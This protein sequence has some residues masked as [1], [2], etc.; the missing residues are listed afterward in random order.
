MIRQGEQGHHKKLSKCDQETCIPSLENQRSGTWGRL[1]TA[2]W[3]LPNGLKLARR[4][5]NELFHSLDNGFQGKDLPGHVSRFNLYARTTK[6]MH[7]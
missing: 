3:L 7:I 2:V 5:S 6:N 1:H 4:S